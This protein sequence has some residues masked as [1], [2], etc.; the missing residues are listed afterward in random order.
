MFL[1]T[2]KC[3]YALGIPSCLTASQPSNHPERTSPR[4]PIAAG[5]GVF[6]VRPVGPLEQL[7]GPSLVIGQ[8]LVTAQ[9]PLGAKPMRRLVG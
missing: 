5:V 8:E 3:K 2:Q 4:D 7:G 9:K 6:L 1:R